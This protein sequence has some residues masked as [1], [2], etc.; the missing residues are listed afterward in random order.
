MNADGRRSI[1]S[2]LKAA[3]MVGLPLWFVLGRDYG[4][5]LVAPF[6]VPAPLG[7]VLRLARGLA[8][9]TPLG[10]IKLRASSAL[11][12]NWRTEVWPVV[13]NVTSTRR[14]WARARTPALAVSCFF[15]AGVRLVS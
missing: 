7:A 11:N 14:L 1:S 3:G 9:L 5:F 13:L 2:R 10:L 4:V 12:G 8:V 15:C 6:F